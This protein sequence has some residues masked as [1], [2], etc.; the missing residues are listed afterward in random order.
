MKIAVGAGVG[1]AC[2]WLTFRGTDLAAVAGML[3]RA[4]WSPVVV[5]VLLVAATVIVVARRWQLLVD[6]AAPAGRLPPFV[7][8]VVVGQMLN[9]LL[10]IRLGE[11][12]R[13]YWIGCAEQQPIARVFAALLLERF[14]DVVVLA[15]GIVLLLVDL[16]LPPWARRSGLAA[17]ALSAVALAAAAAA[18]RWGPA[19]VR[20]LERP[21]P[22]LAHRL[23]R[24]FAAEGGMAVDE[25]RALGD[26]R[27]SG[28]V[29]TL[30]L[31][32]V[33]LA[34]A[35]NYVL[36]SALGL[37]LPPAIALMLFV[38]LQVGVAPASTPGNLGV[39]HYL[40]VLV[41]T[42]FDVDRAAAVAY[43]VVLH[44]VAYGPKIV[45]GAL[46][47]AMRDTPVFDRAAWVRTA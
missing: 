20:R 22:L 14:A 34:V 41:L 30:S 3:A 42:G 19:V 5:A 21:V 31:L 39:F 6:R 32:I 8:A 12:V 45:C 2:L 29:W 40:V 38:V 47:M 7:S 36:F 46:I 18:A 33:A 1:A 26:W 10:P 24:V 25:L 44:A 23:R 17:L 37:A 15:L 43:A 28:R 16:S 4:R 11:A 9:V 35:T 13:A 27:A